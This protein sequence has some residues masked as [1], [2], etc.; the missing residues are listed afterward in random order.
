MCAGKQVYQEQILK[1]WAPPCGSKSI[2]QITYQKDHKFSEVQGYGHCSETCQDT[3]AEITTRRLF[4][5]TW[6]VR[7]AHSDDPCTC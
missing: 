2:A 4:L 7:E 3:K 5:S 1:S 6:Q